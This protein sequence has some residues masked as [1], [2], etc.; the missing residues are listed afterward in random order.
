MIDD[1][2][3]RRKFPPAGRGKVHAIVMEACVCGLDLARI[4]HLATWLGTL[5]NNKA[6]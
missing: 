2:V 6:D 5:R 4:S 3:N 1:P